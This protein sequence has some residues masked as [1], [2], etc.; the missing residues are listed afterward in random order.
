[1]LNK[2]NNLKK[3]EINPTGTGISRNKGQ[4]FKN[5]NMSAHN[6]S[7]LNALN[8]SADINAG[9]RLASYRA[10][11]NNSVSSN[12]GGIKAIKKQLLN[13]PTKQNDNSYIKPTD[14]SIDMD[15][16]LHTYNRDNI[17]KNKNYES[18]V[19]SAETKGTKINSN[20]ILID[21]NEKE[22]ALD[23]SSTSVIDPIFDEDYEEIAFTSK[24][25]DFSGY[26]NENLLN[27]YIAN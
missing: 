6:I 17:D 20:N 2:Y 9:A 3:S 19:N 12:K 5:K 18:N 14:M 1:M 25:K 8:T 16:H 13:N 21:L 23:S 24:F 4:N 11:N 15:E 7:G 26:Y 22:E 27:M 10:A